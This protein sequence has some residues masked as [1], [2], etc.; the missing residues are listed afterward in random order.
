MP[1]ALRELTKDP[2]PGQ[3]SHRVSCCGERRYQGWCGISDRPYGTPRAR[4]KQRSHL[5]EIF[6]IP[7]RVGKGLDSGATLP[8]PH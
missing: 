1:G 4:A 6:E 2:K 5:A 8:R 7:S 3:R